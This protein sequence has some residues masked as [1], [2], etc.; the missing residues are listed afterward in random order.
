MVSSLSTLLLA[1]LPLLPTP[2]LLLSPPVLSTYNLPQNFR[3]V[4]TAKEMAGVALA[5]CLLNPSTS[6]PGLQ[7]TIS[8]E[9]QE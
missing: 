3:Q 1:C 6:I 7:T 4:G 5:G 8:E 9:N 2:F